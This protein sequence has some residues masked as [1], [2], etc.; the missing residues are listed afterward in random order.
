MISKYI[1]HPSL[2]QAYFACFTSLRGVYSEPTFTQTLYVYLD[3]CQQMHNPCASMVARVAKSQ[4]SLRSHHQ[5]NLYSPAECILKWR[6][7]LVFFSLEKTTF[8]ISK[9][10]F[11]RY[12][13]INIYRHFQIERR[14]YTWFNRL[15]VLNRLIL[16]TINTKLSIYFT[17]YLSI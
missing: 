13:L 14:L 12:P 7:T 2:G 17:D 4:W 16:G 6:A 8:G 1:L 10:I 3:A 5:V 11:R 9:T 15:V